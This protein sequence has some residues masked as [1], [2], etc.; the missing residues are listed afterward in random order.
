M[1]VSAYDLAR[2][3]IRDL[4]PYDSAPVRSDFTRLNANEATVSPYAAP[5][6]VA[7]NRY[8]EIRSHSL[9]VALAALF[10]VHE[11]NLCPTRG[12]S[13]A[14]DLLVRTFCRA[15]RDNVVV[16]PPTFD[17]Y[18]AYANMQAAEVRCAPL[19]SEKDFCVDW[20]AVAEQCDDHTRIVFVCSPNNPTGTLIPSGEILQFAEE[21]SGKL[22]VVVDEAYVEYSKQHSL[23][24]EVDRFD[25]LVVLRTLSKAYALAGARCGALIGCNEVIRL[26]S[27]LM[28]PYAFS[29][30]ATRLV[31]DALQSGNIAAVKEQI[32]RIST[33]RER[34]RS[35]LQESASI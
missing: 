3:E 17:M 19:R 12:S 32:K 18:A 14:I 28:S 16:L 27:A 20:D 25:N 4:V 6:A 11:N 22:I 13:E 34:L 2:P 8:P 24:K 1:L 33:E 21:M 9:R 35:C 7:N 30:P 23:A 15:Y 31:L 26:T 29:A 10:Q 5:V